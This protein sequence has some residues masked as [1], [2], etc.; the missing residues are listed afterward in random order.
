MTGRSAISRLLR[1]LGAWTLRFGAMISTLTLSLLIGILFVPAVRFLFSDGVTLGGFLFGSPWFPEG[2]SW[3]AGAF[4]GATL[5]TSALAMLVAVPGSLVL[6]IYLSEYSSPVMRQR[7]LAILD[8]LAAVPAVLYG[9]FALMFVTPILQQLLGADRVQPYNTL[10]AALMLGLFITPY[11]TSL[12]TQPLASA[13]RGKRRAALALGA[14]RVESLA[15][16]VLPDA[17]PGLLSAAVLGF[18]RA[19]GESIIVGMAAGLGPS[20]GVHLF[21]SAE[22]VTGFILRTGSGGDGAVYAFG[23]ILFLLTVTL[24][25]LGDRMGSVSSGREAG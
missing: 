13:E 2:G 20:P 5:Q 22:T 12:M 15:R 21:K 8:I 10:A 6:S 14:T 11:V 7:S 16:I 23:A 9:L 25:F 1:F 17:L 18:S 4:F 24:N 3:G 19:L